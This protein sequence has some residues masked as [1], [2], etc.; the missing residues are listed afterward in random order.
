MQH[1]FPEP[2]N[3]FGLVPGVCQTLEYPCNEFP[4]AGEGSEPPPPPTPP[5]KTVFQKI[6]E[7]IHQLP[8]D[9]WTF[10]M[11]C[12]S[13]EKNKY[14][15]RISHK[16]LPYTIHGCLDYDCENPQLTISDVDRHDLFTN[17]EQLTLRQLLR[18]LR[19]ACDEKKK[20]DRRREAN[21]K[22]QKL[23]PGCRVE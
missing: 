12:S 4:C 2:F 10:D 13:F 6:V 15:A 17:S 18:D 22:L 8:L 20:E 16:K 19:I 9:G 7:D 23:F 11:H 1:L 5:P 21:D 14:W 3:P